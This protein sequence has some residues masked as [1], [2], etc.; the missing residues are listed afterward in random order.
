MLVPRKTA[1]ESR[2]FVFFLQ[3]VETVAPHDAYGRFYQAISADTMIDRGAFLAMSGDGKP[4]SHEIFALLRT[5]DGA[6]RAV[7]N[8]AADDGSCRFEAAWEYDALFTPLGARGWYV[9]KDRQWSAHIRVTD[10]DATLTYGE[11]DT[12][13]TQRLNYR[14]GWM[15]DLD[16]SAV[17]LSV[18]LRRYD[19]RARGLQK[20]RW[21]GYAGGKN[22][23]FL[24]DA[25]LALSHVGTVDVP[26]A[27]DAQGR[28]RVL[29]AF[30]A[31]EMLVGLEGPGIITRAKF[32]L[33][34]DQDRNLLRFVFESARRTVVQWREGEEALAEYLR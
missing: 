16:P 21:I 25:T 4:L 27:G 24:D 19:M 1:T 7:S 11:G 13:V 28:S 29:D 6:F 23:A 14:R 34:T 2:R 22:H 31:D 20:F 18:M 32:R 17:P 12:A 10:S 33:W 26:V 3:G 9:Q 15:I 5:G 30:E 8:H